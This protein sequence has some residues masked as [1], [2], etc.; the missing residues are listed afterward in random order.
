MNIDFMFKTT[1]F[2][3]C[4]S[5][6]YILG[7]TEL[8]RRPQVTAV[9]VRADRFL[10]CNV[11]IPYVE[12][13]DQQK[14]ILYHSF[15]YS[16][17]S[18][19]DVLNTAFDLLLIVILGNGIITMYLVFISPPPLVGVEDCTIFMIVFSNFFSSLTL[20]SPVFKFIGYYKC[21]KI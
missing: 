15:Q 5:A 16:S 2:F 8:R 19:Q 9:S 17:I 12:I 13:I 11:Y 18:N 1:I 10:K 3:Q 7:Y 6:Q 4:V 20:N 21:F 14:E